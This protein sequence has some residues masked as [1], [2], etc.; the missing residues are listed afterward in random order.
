VLAAYDELS[1]IRA[2]EGDSLRYGIV[3]LSDGQDANSNASLTQLEAHLQPAEADPTG[4][5]IHTIAIGEDAAEDVLKKI[6]GAAHGRFWKTEQA[7][8]VVNVYRDIAAYF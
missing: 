3:V 1:K 5:Q 4:I 7:S 2:T 8:D 6:A